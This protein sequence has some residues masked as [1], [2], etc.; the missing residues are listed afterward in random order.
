MILGFGT[1]SVLYTSCPECYLDL[2][3]KRLIKCES[4]VA[5]LEETGFTRLFGQ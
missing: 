3:M 1:C 5:V 4:I 2:S